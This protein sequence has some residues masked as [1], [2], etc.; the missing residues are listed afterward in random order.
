MRV[1]NDFTPVWEDTI[2]ISEDHSRLSSS[3]AFFK[4]RKRSLSITYDVDSSSSSSDAPISSVERPA[5]VT[6]STLL[7]AFGEINPPIYSIQS[8]NHENRYSTSL[9]KQHVSVM[10]SI[11]HQSLLRKDYERAYRAFALLLR[12]PNSEASLSLRTGGQWGIGAEILL[13]HLPVS[14]SKTA[15]DNDDDLV[16]DGNDKSIKVGINKEM[17]NLKQVR[18]YYEAFI[19][20]FP[21]NK[22]W[23]DAVDA[24][25]FYPVLFSIWIYEVSESARLACR[26]LRVEHQN[27]EDEEDDDDDEKEESEEVAES[28]IE[29]KRTE[30][31]RAKEIVTRLQEIIVSPPYDRFV[32]LLRIRAML[33][34]WIADLYKHINRMSNLL[35][36]SEQNEFLSELEESEREQSRIYFEKSSRL[37]A[38]T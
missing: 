14:R 16:S 11:L 20:Q 30:L 5:K 18:D 33:S 27:A 19:L 28:L 2:H 8:L 1:I 10:T 24:R 21:F 22:V 38:V 31:T 36:Q 4:K 12:L 9:Q 35:D 25:T 26:K 17:L 34:L 3:S 7:D 15:N 23:P 29:I 37:M 32:P 6:K 13:R